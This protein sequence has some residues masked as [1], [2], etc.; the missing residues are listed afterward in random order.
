MKKKATKKSAAASK[1]VKAKTE[2]AAATP[3]KATPTKVVA[4]REQRDIEPGKLVAAPWNPRGTITPESV[5][6]LAASIATVGIVEPVVV[7][8][9]DVATQT[10]IV[11]SGH[12]RVKA[13][14]VAGLATVPCDVLTGIDETA[15]RRMTFIENL[16]R[17][18]V[19]PLLESTLVCNLIADGMTTDEIAA[20]IGR[21][22]KWVLRRKNLSNLSP[23]W[24]KRIEKGENITTDCLEHIAAYPVEVQ[25]KMKKE[26]THHASAL[27]WYDI[28]RCFERESQ[29][30]SKAPFDTTPCK[31]CANNTG[32]SP[33]LFDWEKRPSTLGKC[34][35]AKC[36]K[37]KCAAHF[38]AIVKQAESDGVLIVKREPS[39]DVKTSPTRTKKCSALYIYKQSYYPNETEVKWGEPPKKEKV[40][41]ASEKEREKELAEKREKR[42]HNKA[43]RALVEWCGGG[44]AGEPCN[45]AKLIADF[46]KDPLTGETL[47]YAPFYVAAAFTGLDSYQMLGSD[48]DKSKGAIAAIFGHLRIPAGWANVAASQIISYL[49]PGRSQGYYANLNANLILAMFPSIREA[50]GEDVAEKI[51]S[52]AEADKLKCPTIRWDKG[53]LPKGPAAGEPSDANED[54]SGDGEDAVEES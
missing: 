49:D 34:L 52:A 6:D 29:N 40:S 17:K 54:A 36:Y 22:R 19:D 5:A 50:I 44:T 48:T 37:K 42:E 33:D 14:I 15:A 47:P 12:R 31:T 18:D 28:E 32:C 2:T 53:V 13:A 27:R 23:S 35:C 21:D 7:M 38:E 41:K 45:L 3:E 39:Y 16:Q 46:F 9:G 4:Q 30:L 51:I 11:I 8:P 20:E 26:Y 24:R 43:I 10:Y 25:E 1:E